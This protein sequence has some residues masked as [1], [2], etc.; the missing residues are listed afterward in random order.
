MLPTSFFLPF[1]V[2]MA[3]DEIDTLMDM[4]LE[5]LSRASVTL[6]SVAKKE[7]SLKSVPAAVHVITAEQIR[8]SGA[9]SVPEALSLAPGIHVSRLSE[10]NWAVSSR[11]VNEMLFNK[12]LVSIDGRSVFN[13]ITSGVIW[14][15]L[16]IMM[17]DIDRI[18]VLLG[19]A[20]TMWG[21]NA[22][23]GVI[24][25]ITKDADQTRG[26]YTELMFGGEDHEELNLRLGS[27]VNQDI[28][29]RLSFKAIRSAYSTEDRGDWRSYNT[30]LRVDHSTSNSE[31]T[32]QLGAYNTDIHTESST[33][34]FSVM[35]PTSMAYDEYSRGY[36]GKL[37]IDT[38]L[39]TGMLSINLWSD[40][41]DLNYE[42]FK[43]NYRNWDLD[44][45]Y[46]L[47]V[48]DE[49][50]L[51]VGGGGRGTKSEVVPI[52]SGFSMNRAPVETRIYS[53]LEQTYQ[54]YNVY[55]QL[56]TDLTERL[57]S[58]V[59]VKVE[60][61]G[62]VDRYEWLPQAR[63][64]Y[65]YSPSH[66]F[67][68]GLGRAV[69]TPSMVD[70]AS[71]MFDF[72]V[73]QLTENQSSLDSTIVRGEQNLSTESV[74]TL[75]M[76]HRYY[77]SSTLST[78][79]TLYYSHYDNVRGIAYD[80]AMYQLPPPVDP[81]YLSPME[82]Y[83]YTDQ[84]EANTWGVEL[85]TFWQPRSDF[86]FNVNYSFR[87]AK[88]KCKQ[89]GLC[90]DEFI[91]ETR[92]RQPNHMISAQTM[93]DV[94]DT[95]QF[96]LVYKYIHGKN[97]GFAHD[98]WDKISTLDARLAWQQK[99]DWPRVEVLVDGVFND[100]GY[101]ESNRSAAYRLDRQVYVKAVWMMQ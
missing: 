34:H 101:Y 84:I 12:L 3:N 66:Q 42:Y 15:N 72:N 39:N 38:E 31:V 23:N 11:G 7:Q 8:R 54:S 74:V 2:A 69:V 65:D 53:D 91:S 19:P 56:E 68:V 79:T 98:G 26:L 93:W 82:F 24:N 89:A 88:A 10:T 36:F 92:T 9:R 71:T 17:A 45:Y 87:Q 62:L 58:Y 70:T 43:G 35:A 61:F 97:N 16:N 30:N 81:W 83:K 63:F 55:G 94:T 22:A 18:E 85:A 40:K 73:E 75:D 44:I 4:S 96:D 29:A 48:F 21:G 47:P 28:D 60:Y 52:V 37:N 76:G 32:F 5:D 57:T 20:G 64:S 100:H 78:S 86:R 27:K 6:T 77:M 67:W 49:S 51:T 25:I 99:Q 80:H 33:S 14:E 46:R 13:P 50:E 90:V 1:S 95:V 59:G 41:H